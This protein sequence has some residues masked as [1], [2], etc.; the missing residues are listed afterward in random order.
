MIVQLSYNQVPA[1]WEAIKHCLIKANKVPES[2]EMEFTNRQLERIMSGE[3]QCWVVFSIGAD[4]SRQLYAIVTTRVSDD[5]IY[6][7]RFLVIESIYGFRK[8]EA[9]LYKDGLEKLRK[10]AEVMKCEAIIA[11]TGSRRIKEM[12]LESGFEEQHTTYRLLTVN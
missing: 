4:G 3:G 12:L 5:K 8:I 10:F 6:G 7:V 1:F 11:E 9:D 2:V